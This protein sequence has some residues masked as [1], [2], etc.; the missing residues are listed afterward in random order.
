MPPPAMKER[1]TAAPVLFTCKC[2]N[3][4]LWPLI[5]ALKKTQRLLLCLAATSMKYIEIC[6]EHLYS[7]NTAHCLRAKSAWQP[8]RSSA[9]CPE[10]NDHKKLSL[11]VLPRHFQESFEIPESIGDYEYKSKLGNNVKMMWQN[12]ISEKYAQTVSSK[13]SVASHRTFS[14]VKGLKYS[15]NSSTTGQ[16]PPLSDCLLLCFHFTAIRF[17]LQG[18]TQ[19]VQ[20]A[21]VTN[22]VTNLVT[23]DDFSLQKNTAFCAYDILW[24]NACLNS[25]NSVH[26]T[27]ETRFCRSWMPGRMTSP[28]LQAESKDTE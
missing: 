5:F 3:L 26:S 6:T 12:V 9:L 4:F 1:S 19:C 2:W 10:V 14:F 18:C 23:L 13:V 27:P 22:L 16:S 25:V 24:L 11:H 8:L 28:K 20:N 15:R 17:E 7:V 21:S